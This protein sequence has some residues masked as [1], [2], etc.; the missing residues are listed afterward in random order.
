M[1]HDR[2]SWHPP[3]PSQGGPGNVSSRPPDDTR[4]H[5]HRPAE[6]AQLPLVLARIG[7][8]ISQSASRHGEPV[9]AGVL[10][11]Q[12]RSRPG[13]QTGGI[14]T[15][16]GA[17][18]A[19]VSLQGG[20]DLLPRRRP[21]PHSVDHSP[22]PRRRRGRPEAAVRM[23][24]L[25]RLSRRGMPGRRCQAACHDGVG[26]TRR[27]RQSHRR[28]HRGPARAVNHPATAT[29]GYP[30]NPRSGQMVAIVGG[31]SAAPTRRYAR[32]ITSG[33]E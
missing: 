25:H 14:P 9:S 13:G 16:Q 31:P 29:P 26:P 28:C 32:A 24:G 30:R 12:R 18:P 17:R 6:Q 1:V 2:E 5:V 21:R 19:H 20:S 33:P 11:A 22:E 15:T 23:A 7:H 4:E 10:A 27:G 8:G 3:S